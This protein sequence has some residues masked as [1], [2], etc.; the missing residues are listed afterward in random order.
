M[1]KQASL[2]ALSAFVLTASS[3]A[4]PPKV[5]ASVTRASGLFIENRGQWDAQAQFLS[6]T[7][8]VDEWVTSQGVVLDFSKFT[9]NAHSSKRHPSGTLQGQVVRVS[10]AN[11]RPSQI[12]GIAQHEG[13]FNYLLGNDQ[14]KWATGAR[15]FS[16]A[17]AEQPYDGIA[18]RYYTDEGRPRYDLLV[19]P[20]ADSSQV[21]LKV[22]GANGLR[23]LEN[24]DLAI[25]TSL[26]TVQEKGLVAYQEEGGSR[27]PVPCHM[28]LDGNIVRFETGTYDRTRPLIIDPLVY[29]TAMGGTNGRDYFAGIA[30][31]P[32]GNAVVLS[33]TTSTNYPTT[34]GAYQ[35]TEPCKFEN[36]ELTELNAN[37]TGVIFS[38]FLGGSGPNYA[39]ALAVD[40]SGNPVITG[41]TESPD[42]PVTV[43]AY[44]KTNQVWPRPTGF[45]TKMNTNGTGLIFSTLLGGSKGESDPVRLALDSSGNVLVAGVTQAS[46]FPI[47]AGAL[48]STITT[49]QSDFVT[50]LN[51][52]GSALIFS[53]FL[54]SFGDA[55]QGA[56]F[57]KSGYAYVAGFSDQQD[58]PTTAGA[59]QTINKATNGNNGFI[60]KLNA[61]ASGLIYGTY[62]GGST[63]DYLNCLVVDPLGNAVV[64]GET[65]STDFPT[66]AGAYQT[67]NHAGVG[68]G[69][70][71]VAK[72][73]GTG[74]KLAFSTYL[75][76]TLDTSINAIALD[77]TDN[78]L[79]TG[80][81]D[82]SDFPTTAG[83][84]QSTNLIH[85][86]NVIVTQLK[87]NGTGLLYSSLLGGYTGE[88]GDI[89]DG[90]VVNSLGQV[91]VGGLASSSDFPITPAAWQ[92]SVDANGEP[93][94][95][96]FTPTSG[97]GSTL[98]QLS[99]PSTI[100]AGTAALCGLT[101]NGTTPSPV[102]IT[103]TGSG[104][105]RIPSSV[106]IPAGSNYSAFYIETDPI[107]SPQN[108]SVTATHGSVSI[109]RNMDVIPMAITYLSVN[110]SPIIGGNS[111]TVA[112]TL[113]ANL[114]NGMTDT[115]KVA[116][117][118]PISTSTPGGFPYGGNYIDFTVFTSDVAQLTPASITVSMGTYS[119][120][121]GFNIYPTF[122]SA[123]FSS[124]SVVG[125][126]TANL[127]VTTY[128][129]API[130]GQQIL[131]ETLNFSPYVSFP[132]QMYVQPGATQVVFPVKTTAVTTQTT[133]MFTVTEG[134]VTINV[135]LT[136][137]P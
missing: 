56:A 94:A 2:A 7:P 17:R 107:G 3:Y 124:P 130:N 47:T 108:I 127:T 18:V 134:K 81:T 99:V 10:F 28:V 89:G 90:I 23:M 106:V 120:T 125:G 85:D 6:Q 129:P 93:F 34:T 19:K 46:D 32:S 9:P 72:L 33:F 35:T 8:G 24:G 42:F 14:S 4:N 76:G 26:G 98:S 71:F 133:V 63:N 92:S 30:A 128:I 25:D 109:M 113:S 58:I 102:T 74:A 66:T 51:S 20:G 64:G 114:G 95:A 91:L 44:Q 50:K 54:G 41:S 62:L 65:Y 55:I 40:S 48:K 117:T 21:G 115:V 5:T 105:G 126:T 38:T 136:I 119:K 67:T 104:P 68:D 53:T 31:E 112:M 39:S 131:L 86:D 78:V 87:G 103:L 52:S 137:K 82:C 27:T 122:K 121:V 37:G 15:L 43:N 22:E 45:V 36:V 75:D 80:F 100:I 70:G 123:T 49:F 97:T 84:Y 79:V 118:G 12:T 135:P 57:D 69:C 60:L 111:A 77:S 13:R 59:Y 83:A 110:P 116:T 73:N 88:Y 29:S 1:L 11:A 96:C 132:S 16:E 61:N 101:L